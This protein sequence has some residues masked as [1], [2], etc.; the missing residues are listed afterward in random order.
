MS[1]ILAWIKNLLSIKHK[2]SYLTHSG[3]CTNESST[4]LPM[5]L[6]KSHHEITNGKIKFLLLYLL[7]HKI[8]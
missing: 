5:A 4:F 8:P 6:P 1:I 7:V 3:Y 2:K